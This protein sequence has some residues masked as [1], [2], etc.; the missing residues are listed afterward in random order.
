M[1]ARGFGDL[2]IEHGHSL[3]DTDLGAANTKDSPGRVRPK[4]L[5]GVEVT[6]KRLVATL[7]RAS[8]T[9]LRLRTTQ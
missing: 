4:A 5:E 9:V 2:S 6:E 1:T 8:W 7:P 3:H